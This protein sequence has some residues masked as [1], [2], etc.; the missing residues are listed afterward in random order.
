MYKF[1][2][3]SQ[4]GDVNCLVKGEFE[5][6]SGSDGQTLQAMFDAGYELVTMTP[7][8]TG[9]VLLALRKLVSLVRP[10]GASYG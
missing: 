5:N 8:E 1:I 9:F 6:L 3:V 10:S 2:R 4:S 7:L